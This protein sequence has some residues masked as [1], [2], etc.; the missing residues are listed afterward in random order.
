MDNL[1]FHKYKKYKM[2]YLNMVGGANLVECKKDDKYSCSLIEVP[3]PVPAVKK[4][5]GHFIGIMRHGIR[6]DNKSQPIDQNEKDEAMGE[7]LAMD[8]K[9]QSQENKIYRL[10]DPPIIFN[11]TKKRIDKLV[12]KLNESNIPNFNEVI[13]SPF[14]RCWQTSIQMCI[15]LNINQLTIDYLLCETLDGI[16][17]CF[18]D[19]KQLYTFILT[20]NN[21]IQM[22]LLLTKIQIE[23]EIRDYLK[24]NNIF[25][26]SFKILFIN[27]NMQNI[28]LEIIERM[29]FF[30]QN[31]KKNYINRNV[32]LVTHGDFV[33]L[34]NYYEIKNPN[35]RI[36]YSMVKDFFPTECGI[37]VYKNTT[38]IPVKDTTAQSEF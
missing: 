27:D 20:N 19:N 12:T 34:I 1:Y 2:K 21:N 4:L 8:L 31:I 15:R 17:K 13:S 30:I 32:L 22:Y 5:G 37:R 9:L 10:H 36:I 29:K 28:E 25:K 26:Q 14:R 6:A 23:N 11:L 38:K 16:K 7:W 3:K 24:K 18:D 33:G 35:E